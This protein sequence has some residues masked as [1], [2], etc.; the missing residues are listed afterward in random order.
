MNV[1]R[2]I[3]QKIDGGADSGSF[4]SSVTKIAIISIAM[5]LAVMVVSFAILQ[6]F[7]NEIQNK[8][9]SFGAH[10]QISRYDTN[11]S[12][13]VAPIAGPK[14]VQELKEFPEVKST[15]PYAVKTAIIKTKDEVLGVVLKGIAETGG[16]SPMRQN[17][18]AGKFISFPDSSAS[19][20]VLIS[21]KVADKLRLAVGEKALFYFIQ[22]PPRI[23]QFRV[24]GI[25]STGLDEFDEVYVIGDIRQIRELNSPAWPDSLVGG[26]EVVLK[27]FKTLDKTADNFYERLPYDLKID[28][29]TEQ[30]A[31]LFDWLQ[32]LNRNVIIFL[33][34]I[35]FVATFNMVATIFIMILERTN[36]IGILKALGATDNQIRRMF[37]FRGLSLTLRGMLIGNIVAVGFCAIQYY[38]KVIPLDPENY[39]M[40][41]VP[42]SW[43][44][45]MLLLL[46][47]ATFAASLL[48]VLI[49]TYLIARIKPVV[50]IKFD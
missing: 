30:Y 34:L 6:G 45:Q 41:R 11:N 22:N 26:M 48:A 29:I 8:I 2:Y 5:G 3:S 15:Q 47:V 16:P 38:F 43:D 28:K 31:Q 24:S 7:R 9:F 46:N 44:P 49:P 27:D 42:I 21:R 12:L 32:L 20:D 33:L 4:T 17:L 10:L 23:R 19:D 25:Y 39:Y 40:D 35:I 13:E 14:L 36:M 18:V 50:A 1:S 37:F